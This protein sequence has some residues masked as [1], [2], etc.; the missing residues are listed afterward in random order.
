MFE[1]KQASC[2]PDG[3]VGESGLEDCVAWRLSEAGATV[4]E[5]KCGAIK[6]QASMQRQV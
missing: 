2:F 6:H 3:L 5:D 1:I 4:P